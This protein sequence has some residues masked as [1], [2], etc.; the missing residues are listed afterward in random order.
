MPLIGLVLSSI[1]LV[2]STMSGIGQSSWKWPLFFLF[3]V[4]QAIPVGFISSLYAYGTVIKAMTTTGAVTGGITLYTLLQKNP[5]YDL[6]QWGRALTGL[7]M[8]FLL[9]GVIHILEMF[10]ILPYGFLPYNEAFFCILGA[11][12]FS[13]YL[14]HHTRLIVGGKSAKYQMNEK[15]YILGAMTLYSDIVDI[16]LYILRLLGELDDR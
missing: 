6:S 12:L 15:D 14:A 5:K 11:G 10:G 16:F 7:S 2:L 1:S 13:L 9:Y 4:G 3:T 8:A